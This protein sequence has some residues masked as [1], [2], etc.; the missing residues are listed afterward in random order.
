MKKKVIKIIRI[1][2]LIVFIGMISISGW[3]LYDYYSEI[4]QSEDGVEDLKDLIGVQPE[5]TEKLD[6]KIEWHGSDKNKYEKIYYLNTDFV[7]WITIE[8]T[9]IDYPVMQTPNDEQY[10]LRRDFYKEYNSAGTLFCKAEADIEKPSDNIVIYGHHMNSGTMFNDLDKY[11]S[12]E[13]YETHK[14]I[15]F[16]TIYDDE[17]MYEVIAAFRTDV[18]PGTYEYYNFID[19]TEEEFNT[20][21]QNAVS[22]TPYTIETKAEY[23]DKLITLSTCAYHVTNGRFVVVAK[24]IQ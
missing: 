15:H 7:G 18:N 14:Y 20:Y 8:D 23:G 22:K 19:G 5:Q 24:K 9:M 17:A 16:G 10:Y 3:Y 11:E 13:F 21:I 4:K 6:E 12:K 1:I 2:L